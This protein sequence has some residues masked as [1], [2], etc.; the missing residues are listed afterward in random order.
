MESP[1]IYYKKIYQV[2]GDLS[3]LRVVNALNH[4]CQ[5][6]HGS[7]RKLTKW[8]T[9]ISIQKNW[10]LIVIDLKDCSYIS[11]QLK[12]RKHFAVTVPSLNNKAPMQWFQWKVLPQG[13][14]NSHTMC[15]YLADVVFQSA[16][17]GFLR[18]I[19]HIICMTF[20]WPSLCTENYNICMNVISCLQR[21]GLT[22]A[23]E[24]ITNFLPF[25]FLDFLSEH[26][27][28]CPPPNSIYQKNLWT[29]NEFQK[30][31]GNIN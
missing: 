6:I 27:V 13:M 15:Q 9:C 16:R 26:T 4:G 12:D 20:W 24:K 31:L 18:H 5:C 11:I 19:W 21:V 29:L 8:L 2:A 17:K 28:V 22:I 10:Y 23:T 30:F 14:M 7:Y 3:H 25:Q 1:N